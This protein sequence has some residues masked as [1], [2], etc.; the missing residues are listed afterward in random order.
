MNRGAGGV[1][2]RFVHPGET[3]APRRPQPLSFGVE[4]PRLKRATAEGAKPPP[5]DR[6]AADRWPVRF[7]VAGP[8]NVRAGSLVPATFGAQPI[9]IAGIAGIFR[10]GADRIRVTASGGAHGQRLGRGGDR[11]HRA[12]TAAIGARRV[13]RS[14]H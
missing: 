9:E 8:G 10:L 11:Y 3:G 13:N 7:G 12:G 4:E 14:R 2:H 1:L 6:I 5:I